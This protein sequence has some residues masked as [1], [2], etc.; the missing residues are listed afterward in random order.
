MRRVEI[1][2]AQ[3]VLIVGAMKTID[4]L[5]LETVTGGTQT[6]AG[7]SSKLDDATTQ[8]LTK[9]SA[10]VKDLARGGTNNGQS[11][12]TQMLTMMMMAKMARG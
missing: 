11:Q 7:G 3:R 6:V 9:L 10:D 8:A 1:G 12:T 2:V 5:L 4:M